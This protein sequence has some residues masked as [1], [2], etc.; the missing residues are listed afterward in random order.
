[1]SDDRAPSPLASVRRHPWALAMCVLLVAI[2][3]LIALWDWNWFKGPVE[4]QVTARTGRSFHIAG[5]LDVDLGRV[6]TIRTGHL[7]F[8]NAAWA[9][10]PTMASTDALE[11][12]IEVWPLLLHRQVRIPDLR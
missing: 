10:Q 2:V 1:V 12:G 9:K 6:T 7:E 3:I 5:N 8:G 11:F 4:R